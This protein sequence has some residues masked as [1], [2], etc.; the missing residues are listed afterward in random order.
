MQHENEFK[1]WRD[2][3]RGLAHLPGEK[4]PDIEA[5]HA[6]L[7]AKLAAQ[8]ILQENLPQPPEEAALQHDNFIAL[9]GDQLPKVHEME[10]EKPHENE[11][12]RWRTISRE[13]KEVPG[14]GPTDQA[15][16]FARLQERLAENR[17]SQEE[18]PK[19]KERY[20]MQWTIAACLLAALFVA[21]LWPRRIATQPKEN[22]AVTPQR[23]TA[24]LIAP[25]N[26]LPQ[27]QSATVQPAPQQALPAPVANSAAPSPHTLPAIKGS[28][29]AIV[30]DT[31]T[32]IA[33]FQQPLQNVPV[34]A[35]PSPEAIAI[36]RMPRSIDRLQVV[37]INEL[38]NTAAQPAAVAAGS[39]STV[40]QRSFLSPDPGAGSP[41][42]AA[43]QSSNFKYDV[44]N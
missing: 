12:K 28:S 41:A 8:N 23:I 3:L 44:N 36:K 37:H 14:A 29:P 24:P 35:P 9:S 33:A 13:L 21:M 34:P 5:L 31:A 40:S 17:G 42:L 7:R 39:S 26:T 10:D 38:N 2:R 16:L 18:Q 20:L 25:H 22:I 11:F 15:A 30:R 19:P 27:D 4:Q 6:R 1:S 32:A 43:I